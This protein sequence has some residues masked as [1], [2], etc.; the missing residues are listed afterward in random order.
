MPPL[1]QSADMIKNGCANVD[2]ETP[3]PR[4]TLF[5]DITDPLLDEALKDCTIRTYADG[6]ILLAPGQDNTYVYVLLSG[7][8]RIYFDE[9][10]QSFV[11]IQPGGCV[12]EMSIINRRPVSAYVAA[13][14]T[15]Q[16]QILPED[17]F[18]RLLRAIPAL[19]KNL[20]AILSER[21]RAG[22]Q[23]VLKRAH[24]H[25][26]L[27]KEMKIAR[28]I[29]TSLLTTKFELFSQYGVDVFAIMEPLNAVGGDF[30]DV[31]FITPT[32]L[33]ICVG[34]VSGKGIPASLSMVQSITQLRMEA[35]RDPHPDK[36]LQRVNQALCENNQSDM[37]VTLFCGV[38]DIQTGELTY[39][40]GGHNPPLSDV[41]NGA[42]EFIALPEGT[43]VGAFDN[44]CYQSAALT[45]EPGQSLVVYTDGVTEATDKNGAFFCAERLQAVLNQNSGTD[46]RSLIEAVC[47]EVYAF[48]ADTHPSDDLTLFALRYVAAPVG[49]DI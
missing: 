17:M 14:G 7:G 4:P 23:I 27:Q 1:F 40:N 8:L 9:K 33:F 24:E 43:I 42:F 16:V 29:Q 28:C 41:A 5:A 26:A 6:E 30:Y 3:A 12:G 44:A 15:S 32:K 47:A 13:F 39:A 45:L 11:D 10:K 18:W 22:D 49:P 31:F 2:G 21:I 46:A 35:V 25:L 48:C 19:V 36:I 37:F 34:D 38:F 20:L